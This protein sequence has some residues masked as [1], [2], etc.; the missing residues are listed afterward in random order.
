MS[1]ENFMDVLSYTCFVFGFLLGWYCN[2]YTND[3]LN[4]DDEKHKNT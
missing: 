4:E 1:K 2:K 3:K